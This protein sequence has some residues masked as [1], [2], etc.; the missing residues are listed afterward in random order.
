MATAIRTNIVLMV[1][2][3]IVFMVG[4]HVQIS[5]I[6]MKSWLFLILSG[7]STGA[8]WLCY[9]KAL[10]KG[11]VSKVVSIDKSSVI[12]TI[13]LSFILL[14]EEITVCKVIGMI[15]IASGTIL[16]NKRNNT[17]IEAKGKQWFLYAIGSAIFASLTSILAKIGIENINSILGTAIRTSVVFIMA[18]TV[19]CVTR[20]NNLIKSVSSKELVFI[21]LSGFSTGISW[22]CYYKALQIGPASAIVPIDK[23][24]IVVTCLFSYIVF[25]ERLSLRTFIGLMILTVGTLVM[26]FP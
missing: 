7:I 25:K 21:I 16:M 4:T 22:I 1:S 19:V 14:N 26:L 23:L 11:D 12:L 20:K 17:I 2:W 10:Q 3:M 8:S 5:N 15:L 6:S 24:S 9:Y 18:W 13:I